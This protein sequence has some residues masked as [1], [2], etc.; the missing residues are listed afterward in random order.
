MSCKSDKKAV[1]KAILLKSSWQ[2]SDNHSDREIT[3][4]LYTEL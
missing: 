1:E 3:S 2:F 4:L